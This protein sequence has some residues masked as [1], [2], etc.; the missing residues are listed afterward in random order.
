ML[1]EYIYDRNAPLKEKHVR[2]N[3][4]VCVNKKS[5]KAIMTRWELLSKFRQK[6]TISS[7]VVYKKQRNI[8][9]K[10]LPITKKKFFLITLMLSMLQKIVN[11]AKR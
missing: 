3:Q 11:S 5:R 2:F 9:S 10:L 7:H 1:S 8:C 6:R 4:A